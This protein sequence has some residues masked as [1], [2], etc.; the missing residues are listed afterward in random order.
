M[1]DNNSF[2][3]IRDTREQ[4][5]W[6]F[7]ISKSCLGT[8]SGTMKTGDYT[9]K[10]LETI[11]TIERKGSVQEFAQNLMDDRFYREMD[12]M[13]DFKYA[14][15]VLEFTA[16]DLLNYPDSAKIPYSIKSRIKIKGNFLMSKLIELQRNYIVDIFFA[17]CRGKDISY[18][19]LKAA[20]KN[21]RR[22]TK[23]VS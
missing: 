2:T 17:G 10:G 1:A 8:E 20:N 5:G 18:I 14:Y 12:R 9:I 21:E 7:A 15:L 11:F 23:T 19:L 4:N 16:E 3:I 13:K 22:V 6:D